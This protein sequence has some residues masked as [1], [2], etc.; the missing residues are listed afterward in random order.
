VCGQARSHYRGNSQ[1]AGSERAQF[2]HA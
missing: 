2:A 1:R